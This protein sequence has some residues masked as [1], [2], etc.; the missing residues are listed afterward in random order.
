MDKK[1][2]TISETQLKL[3]EKLQPSG[4]GARLKSLLLSADFKSI[5]KSLIDEVN[6]GYS[7]TP[8]FK[9]V[10]RAFETCPYDKL[11]VVIINSDPSAI[12][13]VA[14]GLAFSCSNT[15]KID[16]PLQCLFNAVEQQ[17]HSGEDYIGNPDLEKWAKQ[18][19]LLLNTALTTRIGK[20][21]AHYEIWNPF[22]SFLLDHLNT[23]NPGTIYVFVGKKAEERSDLI[24]NGQKIFVTH[25][26]TSA[27][28]NI[29]WDN[30]NLFI[31]IN[32]LC[33]GLFD[34]EIVW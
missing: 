33:K 9:Q 14:D 31:E 17:Y 26:A 32:K 15:G 2:L 11:K 16:K 21:G 7:F 10:F 3:Y 12:A 24:V 27:F 29:P 28:K 22:T 4:W 13:G 8:G 23:Y 6:D 30:N 34:E 25:P 5:I 18:G 20:V 1:K 19:V